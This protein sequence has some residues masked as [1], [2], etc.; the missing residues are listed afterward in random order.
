MRR[1]LLT[2]CASPPSWDEAMSRLELTTD[3]ARAPT[4]PLD[5]LAPPLHESAATSATPSSRWPAT[6]LSTSCA[7]AAYRE[8]ATTTEKCAGRGGACG[9][10][11]SAERL[12]PDEH[13]LA[14][15]SALSGDD[16]EHRVSDNSLDADAL[17]AAAAAI[18]G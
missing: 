10:S 12:A 14:A 9:S 18:S 8:R 4:E 15:L 17:A 11:V 16:L 7:T 6:S 13:C 2:L 1:W 5:G 3:G